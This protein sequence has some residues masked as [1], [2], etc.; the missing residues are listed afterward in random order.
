MLNV[1]Y[2]AGASSADCSTRK[3]STGGTSGRRSIR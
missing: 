1:E 3:L 2:A